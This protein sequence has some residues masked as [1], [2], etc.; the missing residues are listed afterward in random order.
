MG[1]VFTCPKTKDDYSPNDKVESKFK[2]YGP[3]TE[4]QWKVCDSEFISSLCY[5]SHKP[6]LV[7]I[8]VWLNWCDECFTANL[9]PHTLSG[10]LVEVDE[11]YIG[12]GTQ[13][14]IFH[15]IVPDEIGKNP[16]EYLE[17][18]ILDSLSV[19][20][21]HQPGDVDHLHCSLTKT[22]R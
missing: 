21:S 13:S 18:Q 12:V 10:F 19:R 11:F 15:V 1:A 4:G 17:E 8:W 5:N 20:M 2:G 9:L 14:C 3:S 16:L 7:L 22:L 6:F